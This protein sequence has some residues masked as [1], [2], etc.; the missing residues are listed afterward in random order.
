MSPPL[1]TTEDKQSYPSP[2]LLPT[3]F[4]TLITLFHRLLISE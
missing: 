4:F 2:Q 1:S 3:Q